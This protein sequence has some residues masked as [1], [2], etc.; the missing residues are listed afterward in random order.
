MR[1]P[2]C[3]SMDD[4]VI[5]SR[6]AEGG[7]ATRR[8]R[9]CIACGRR[10]TTFERVEE[11]QLFVIKRSGSR[12]PFDRAKI[13]DGIRRAAKNRPI[14]EDDISALAAS[15]EDEARE[16]GPEVGSEVVGKA[17]LDRLRSLDPVAYLRFASVYKGFEDVTDFE[18]E[19]G[20]LQKTTS[21]K[22]SPPPPN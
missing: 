8:R 1:C 4:K 15:V 3:N 10:Y 21:P 16:I 6:M 20:L 9:E 18:R 2:Y 13:L 22:G 17:V 11:L 7:S 5:D 19:V 14:S 12:E